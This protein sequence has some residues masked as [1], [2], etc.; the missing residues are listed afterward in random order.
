MM[1]KI[2][3]IL[4][5]IVLLVSVF[6]MPASAAV[7][8]TTNLEAAILAAKS[9]YDGL[10]TDAANAWAVVENASSALGL[11]TSHTLTGSD[12]ASAISDI[13]TNHIGLPGDLISSPDAAKINAASTALGLG[14]LVNDMTTTYGDVVS[15]TSGIAGAYD[16]KK[17]LA[18]AADLAVVVQVVK[19]DA[20]F[21]LTKVVDFPAGV[22]FDSNGHTIYDCGFTPTNTAPGTIITITAGT[23]LPPVTYDYAV[24]PDKK[25]GT[26]TGAAYSVTRTINADPVDTI[27]SVAIA[28]SGGSATATPADFTY[29]P[30]TATTKAVFGLT[31]A[32][33][34]TQSFAHTL[35]NG[36]Y[37]VTV[38][39]ATGGPVTFDLVMD[40]LYEA[41]VNPVY[42]KVGR[43]ADYTVKLNPKKSTFTDP[44][45]LSDYEKVLGLYKSDG[46]TPETIAFVEN[47][48]YKVAAGSI[49]ITF[50]GKD[51]L[52]KL[53][54]NTTYVVKV[55]LKTGQIVSIKLTVNRTGTAGAKSPK[56]G[57]D[58]NSTFWF[59]LLG[60]TM[61]GTLGLGA[62]TFRRR[63]RASAK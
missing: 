15:D 2:L 47:T 40:R 1:K 42:I 21:N 46:T 54:V 48:Q 60:T 10:V 3:P 16:A 38:T 5:A 31:K 23:P 12:L 58:F 4:L 62:V 25:L 18:E 51:F 39:F 24:T 26:Y 13:V 22:G 43:T 37:T 6:A 57:D 50:S 14:S 33:L 34:D 63:K 53:K 56:S 55:E 32:F 49:N 45:D 11:G 29:T 28:G 8:S 44:H 17:A 61:V 41:D 30:A 9:V 35:K 7:D 19:A 20:D 27:T 36:S 52:S 59:A